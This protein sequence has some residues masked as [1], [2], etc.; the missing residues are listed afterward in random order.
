MNSNV[1]RIV[2]MDWDSFIDDTIEAIENRRTSENKGVIYVK[3]IDV[4]RQILTPE[5]MRLLSTVRRSKPG[6]LYALAKLM[7][8]NLKSVMT[9]ADMLHHFGLL[10]LE[11][12]MQGKQKKVRPGIEARK[13]QLELAV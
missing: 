13:I 3:N 11:S 12:Y 5:R 8:R 2:I 1:I 10:K 4:A 7:N 9:D 6:S